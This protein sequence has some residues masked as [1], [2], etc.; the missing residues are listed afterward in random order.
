MPLVAGD[1][2]NVIGLLHSLVTMLNTPKCDISV[3]QCLRHLG[4]VYT[5]LFLQLLS[6]P[7]PYI[8]IIFLLSALC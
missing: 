3:T 6:V 1:H 8:V 4:F 2:M 7:L 5:L